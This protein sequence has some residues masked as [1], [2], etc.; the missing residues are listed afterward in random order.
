[1][2]GII[3]FIVAWFVLGVIGSGFAFAYFQDEYPLIKD[4]GIYKKG[5]LQFAIYTAMAGPF[6]LLVALIW[7]DCGK[8]GWRLC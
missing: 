1:M 4:L 7:T 8:H 2:I 5:N 6:N 3:F